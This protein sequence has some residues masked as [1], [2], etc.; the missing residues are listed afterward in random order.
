MRDGCRWTKR[1]WDGRDQ[2]DE[3]RRMWEARLESSKAELTMMKVLSRSIVERVSI[4]GETEECH[5]H[6]RHQRET[7]ID[8]GQP[9]EWTATER[10]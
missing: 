7:V 10:D 4:A 3:C 2:L 6:H 1:W 9:T 8:A 5:P